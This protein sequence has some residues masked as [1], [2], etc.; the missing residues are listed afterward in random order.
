MN[1]LG[2]PEN[3]RYMHREHIIPLYTRANIYEFSFI[4]RT[5][6]NWN[7]LPQPAGGIA[8]TNFRQF[9]FFNFFI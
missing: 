6:V 2:P 3:Y 7:A 9:F 4:P 5:I 8:V 1:L